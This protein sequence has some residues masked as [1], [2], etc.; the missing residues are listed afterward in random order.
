M[1]C[2]YGTLVGVLGISRRQEGMGMKAFGE[3]SANAIV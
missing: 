3:I 2:K 1:K